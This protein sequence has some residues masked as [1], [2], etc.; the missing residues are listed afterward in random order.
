MFET[1]E[2]GHTLDKRSYEARVPNLRVALVN[3][4]YDLREADFP[5]V[6]LIDGNDRPACNGLLKGMHE[7]MDG[8]FIHLVAL[9]RPTDEEL[10]RPRFWRY[11]RQLPGAGHIGAFIDGWAQTLIRERVLG[12]ADEQEE[13]RRLGHIRDLE[14]ALVQDGALLLKF[15]CHLPKD[16]LRKRIKKTRKNPD[17]AWQLAGEGD[18]ELYER[19]DEAMP[20]AER[21]VR[22]TSTGQAPWQII[23]STDR[24]YLGMTMAE[25]LLSALQKRLD[26]A[27]ATTATA[28]PAAAAPPSLDG[29]TILDSIDLTQSLDKDDYKRELEQQQG[30][31]A[32]LARAAHDKGITSVLVFEGWDAAGKGGV[33]RRVCA[34]LDPRQFRIVP[35]AAP[36]DEELAHHYLWRFWKHL[37]KAGKILIFDRSW[38]GRVLVERVEGFAS[39]AEWGRAYAEI[40][41]FEEQL[42]ASGIV[43]QKYWLHISPEEQLA[44]FQAREHTPY[45]KHK[46][47]EDDY[48]NREKWP[49]YAH[50]VH[51]MFTRTSTEEAPWHLIAANDKRHGRVDVLRNYCRALERRL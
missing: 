45:K 47:T 25:T 4:Q 3:A 44:R 5:V 38:Y 46:I 17:S 20:V 29:L 15:W 11:W 27:S 10:Q 1:A 14:Q 7:W 31:L 24:R 40:R 43:L 48:R 49:Q 28:S 21:I 26:Q 18:F 50:A 23:E 33:I 6:I 39:E 35:V 42:C 12:E 32:H 34:P 30:R 37:P 13:A 22:E 51:E 9:G 36:T 41:D 19:Y 2:L 8:R 16:E